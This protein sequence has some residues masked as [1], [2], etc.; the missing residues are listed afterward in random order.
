MQVKQ[1]SPTTA[2]PMIQIGSPH[3]QRTPRLEAAMAYS[4]RLIKSARFA[5]APRRWTARE[6]KL[7]GKMNDYELGR[8]LRRGHYEVRKQRRAL[9]IPPFKSRS[10]WKY[11]K[12]SEERLLGTMP[13]AELAKKL[14][15]TFISV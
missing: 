4:S 7:L 15:R 1:E 5:T 12:P 11:W 10:K 13:D 3:W 9:K 6:I 8:R 14:G 2:D